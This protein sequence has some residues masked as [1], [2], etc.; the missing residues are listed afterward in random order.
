MFKLV[1]SLWRSTSSFQNSQ[2]WIIT[3]SL[4]FFEFITLKATCTSRILFVEKSL[5]RSCLN[6]YLPK[7]LYSFRVFI[8]YYSIICRMFCF[9]YFA[10][11]SKKKYWTGMFFCIH[12][13]ESKILILT[14]ALQF[15]FGNILLLWGTKIL[16]KINQTWPTEG[17]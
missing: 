6:P 11:V 8:L 14:C 17:V 9:L 15:A 12:W 13:F 5:Q 1:K 10:M 2:Y 7:L 4:T 3:S 16:Q